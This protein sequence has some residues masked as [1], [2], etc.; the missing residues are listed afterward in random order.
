MERAAVNHVTGEYK[1][2]GWN[3]ESVEQKKCG[4][5]LLCTKSSIEEH[6]EVKEIRARDPSFI[7]TT[8]EVR[9]AACDANHVF[10]VVTEAL[11]KPQTH[12]FTGREFL[13][14]YELEPLSF[15][16]TPRMIGNK[17]AAR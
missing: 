17:K 4:Y 3:V 14:R 7:I 12:R 10:C 11:D 5:D 1:E 13:E 16:A 8:G 6:V 9:S 2:N 15:R